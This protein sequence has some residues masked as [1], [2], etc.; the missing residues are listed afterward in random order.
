MSKKKKYDVITDPNILDARK[1]IRDGYG[2]KGLANKLQQYNVED[3]VKIYYK[4]TDWRLEDDERHD[5]QKLIKIIVNKALSICNR[6]WAFAG[7]PSPP[8]R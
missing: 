2:S 6:G 4:I 7:Y 1:C 8:Y 5:K 3:L